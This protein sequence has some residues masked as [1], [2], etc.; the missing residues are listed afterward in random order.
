MSSVIKD[1]IEVE[2]TSEQ[3]LAFESFIDVM[4]E[5][6]KMTSN[7]IDYSKLEKNKDQVKDGVSLEE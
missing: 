4:V 2:M 3:K 7:K 6:Y 5:I 1:E